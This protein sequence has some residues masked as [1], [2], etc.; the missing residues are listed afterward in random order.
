MFAGTARLHTVISDSS[1]EPN[2]YDSLKSHKVN[3][4]KYIEEFTLSKYLFSMYIYR[5]YPRCVTIQC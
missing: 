2:D 1:L 3:E 4:G 5:I